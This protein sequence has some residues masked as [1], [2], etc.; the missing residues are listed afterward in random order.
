MLISATFVP[1]MIREKRSSLGQKIKKN[2][3]Q[4]KKNLRFRLPGDSSIARLA[5]G[6]KGK[7]AEPP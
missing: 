1:I 6:S 5:P 3:I 7:E 4:S 2:Y